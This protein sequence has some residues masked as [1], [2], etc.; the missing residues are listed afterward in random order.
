MIEGR[1]TSFD[2]SSR[3]GQINDADD[4]EYRFTT[5][6]WQSRGKPA[7]GLLVTFEP[8][9][10][11]AY[12][13]SVTGKAETPVAVYQEGNRTAAWISLGLGMMFILSAFSM[14]GEARHAT[15]PQKA[16]ETVTA[17]AGSMILIGL[18]VMLATYAATKGPRGRIVAWISLVLNWLCLLLFAGLTVKMAEVAAGIPWE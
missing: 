3:T 13:I 18:N 9:S 4:N 11:K 10:G 8:M 1:V 15:D 6:D 16:V 5:A 12:K 2:P 14:L 7:P 17:G